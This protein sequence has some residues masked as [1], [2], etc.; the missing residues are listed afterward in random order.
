MK[1]CATVDDKHSVFGRDRWLLRGPDCWDA[2]AE[3]ASLPSIL[4]MSFHV[5]EVLTWSFH[6]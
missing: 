5:V 4:V 6:V 1:R 2:G 3:E